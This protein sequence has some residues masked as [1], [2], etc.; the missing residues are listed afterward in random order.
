M[1]NSHSAAVTR[2]PLELWVII[3]LLYMEMCGKSKKWSELMLVCRAWRSALHSMP[4]LWCR[5][6]FDKPQWIRELY[7]QRAR[8]RL[9]DVYIPNFPPPPGMTPFMTTDLVRNAQSLMMHVPRTLNPVP[10]DLQSLPTGFCLP[11]LETFSIVFPRQFGAIVGGDNAEL[12]RSMPR[13]LGPIVMLGSNLRSLSLAMSL[14]HVPFEILVETVRMLPNIPALRDLEISGLDSG[15]Y[16]GLSPKLLTPEL[17][18]LNIDNCEP[19]VVVFFLASL[20]MPKLNKLQLPSVGVM[21]TPNSRSTVPD[22]YPFNEIEELFVQLYAKKFGGSGCAKIII[23]ENMQWVEIGP[24]SANSFP[25]LRF[26]FE[27]PE[28][29]KFEVPTF[30][31]TTWLAH[32]F[33]VVDQQ[34]LFTQEVLRSLEIVSEL[35]DLISFPRKGPHLD[36]RAQS[37]FDF[38]NVQGTE[39]FLLFFEHTP[40]LEFIKM[41]RMNVTPFL[42]H[43]IEDV[44]LLPQLIHLHFEECILDK[45]VL[46][47][48]NMQRQS[49]VRILERIDLVRCNFGE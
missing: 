43:L 16:P 12:Y 42:Q 45:E 44:S 22:M 14:L 7:V 48:L 49:Q 6:N 41:E 8:S 28:P 31:P 24:K 17:E 5:I 36:L 4:Y 18:F 33:S 27:I 37:A 15:N 30:P 2:L 3:F 38:D 26:G 32:T 1:I 20:K 11:H 13:L 23:T 10:I 19:E 47:M 40:G 46:H 9:L 25:V 34:L 35:S 21:T 29:G 39:E